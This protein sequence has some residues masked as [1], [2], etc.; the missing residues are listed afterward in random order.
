LELLKGETRNCIPIKTCEKDQHHR[1]YEEALSGE[2][3][4]CVPN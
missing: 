2:K 1:T 3:R 4:D